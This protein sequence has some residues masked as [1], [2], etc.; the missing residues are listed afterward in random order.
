[1]LLNHLPIS[2]STDRFRGWRRPWTTREEFEE[3]RLR[4]A[5]THF[6]FRQGDELLVFPFAEGVATDG[7]AIEFT[8]EEDFPVANALARHALLRSFFERGRQLSGVRPVKFVVRKNLIDGDAAAFFAVYP[9]YSFDIRILAHEAGKFSSGILVNFNSRLMIL[10]TA[11]ELAGRGLDLTGM[12]LLG[13][14]ERESLYV[15]PMF[16]RR[17][18]GRVEEVRDDY[19]LL[20]DARQDR[21]ELGK[22][23]I[24]PSRVQFERVGRAVLKGNYDGFNRRLQTQIFSIS[25]AQNQL[26]R[27]RELA[28][29]FPDLQGELPCCVGLTVR[30][31]GDLTEVHAGIGVGQSRTLPNP[32]YSLRPG[33]S[34]TVRWPVDPEVA[35]NGPY[36]SDGFPRKNPRIGVVFPSNHRGHIETFAAQLRGGI[37][38]S[39][40]SMGMV[41]KFRLQGMDFELAPVQGTDKAQAYRKAA[42][43]VS[44]RDV[45]AALVVVTRDD[46]ALHGAANP[47]YVA[48]AA[49]MS[50]GVPV[51]AVALE[52]ILERGVDYSLN[53]ISLALYA[54]LGGVPWT[55]SVQQRLVHEIVV[56]IGSARIGGDRLSERERLIGITT[57]FSADG[58]Y[59]LG[60]ATTDATSDQYRAVLLESLR[61]NLSELQRRFGWRKGD[62]LR[63]IFHQSFKR[64]KDVEA[65]AVADLVA[66]L[67]DF[68]VEYAFV[69]VSSDHDWKLFDP[70]VEGVQKGGGMKGACVPQRGQVVPLGPRAAV[71]TLTGPKQ[72]K[73]AFQGCPS[74]MLVSIHP[75]STFDSLDYI[76]KQVH[77]LTFMS[78]RTF[79]PSTEPVS[80]KYPNLVVELLGNLRQIPNF[81]PD[82]L[83]T[84]LRESRW[85][86]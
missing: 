39:A 29:N 34:L 25:A 36:D 73:T 59:L 17:L 43:E 78:W 28:T 56:G 40:F 19:A 45:D 32:T 22:A 47:Y 62:K 1:M 10:P 18:L 82:I 7:T 51:Q 26:K 6:V 71:V 76:A 42:I 14:G 67:S 80:I 11:A 44:G 68:E 41:R 77:D 57:V 66:G 30:L 33:G 70:K 5:K 13:E 20:T 12:Y 15:P 54:K 38:G 86:L 27:I 50:Q 79:M 31:E 53:N 55:L 49:L 81:N 75:R 4:L 21:V 35:K 69:Q 37:Q 16:S 23:H 65:D 63:I 52:T 46:R 72:L 84:K 60:N 74:P 64:Y 8:I 9:E 83:T 85:F 24:E 3:V 48:K 2:F 61:D 58:N